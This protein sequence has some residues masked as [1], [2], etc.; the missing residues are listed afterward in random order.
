MGLHGL[1]E[2][3]LYKHL[4][5]RANDAII[6]YNGRDNIID[7]NMK[8]CELFGYSREE[9]LTLSLAD[10][11]KPDWSGKRRGGQVE[12]EVETYG[13]GSFETLDVRKGGTE[14]IVEVTNSSIIENGERYVFSIIRD[15]TEQKKAQQELMRSE[16]IKQSIMESTYGINIWAVDTRCR[17]IFFNDAHRKG[18][19]E[20]WNADI[21]LGECLLNYISDPEYRE[22]VRQNYDKLFQGES[23]HST[24]RLQASDGSYHYYEN[25]GYPVYGESGE[26]IG[27]T[28][29]T[30]D[31]TERIELEKQLKQS[32][33]L[34]RSIMNAPP[35]VIILSVDRD[36]R[37]IFFNNAHREAM[38]K[39]WG[40]EPV[41]G[42]R[43]LDL[44]SDPEYR[45][46]VRSAYDK[47]LA[48]GYISSIDEFSNAN[49]NKLYY[50][51][52]SAPIYNQDGEIIGLTLFI[53]DV[54][55]QTK[56]EE[57]IRESLHE[58]EILLKE[59]HHRVKNN[60]QIISSMLNMQIEMSRNQNVQFEL[61]E[62]QNRINTMAL[63]HDQLYQSDNLA[64]IEI[65]D[66]IRSLVNYV[67]DTF[68]IHGASVNTEFRL[69]QMHLHL[70]QAIPLGLIINELVSNA[71]KYAFQDR[72]SGTIVIGMEE[73][74]GSR[75]VFSVQ[76]DGAG[77]PE[78]FNP[79]SL[80]TLGLQMIRALSQQLE[81]DFTLKTENGVRAEISFSTADYS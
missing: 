69:S 68:R 34:L 50:Q 20:V 25:T 36:Y 23:N 28:F 43:V 1:Q 41:M 14:I 35:D 2:N 7:V 29:Y 62:G 65:E 45:G 79:E 67:I 70:D 66:Y 48:G 21:Q 39:V 11:K 31:I 9:M 15:R 3:I 57:A 6:L 4:F 32:L 24:D 33:A 64:E 56:A 76:D 16:A 17:Y 22:Q 53:L 78:G 26:I 52:I 59:V 73:H 51:N 49:G 12:W 54:T 18:M 27:A 42:Q 30:T 13:D 19:K 61:R 38:Q 46:R 71:M 75:L 40:A 47:V 44:L 80:N 10:L 74:A 77:L 5:M 8:A 63:I 58:K 81:G 60:L 55:E 37:Y 72:E